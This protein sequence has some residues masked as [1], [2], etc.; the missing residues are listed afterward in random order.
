MAVPPPAHPH[1][2]TQDR[3]GPPPSAP[4]WGRWPRWAPYATAAWGV[5][6]AVV[7]TAWAA[8][9][10]TVPWT[11]RVSYAPEAQLLSAGAALLAAAVSLAGVRP[12]GGP[13]RG[14]AVT[15]AWVV[16]LPVFGWGAL[17]LPMY[18]VSLLSGSGVESATGLAQLLL[19]T[20]GSW[21]LALVGL[22]HLRRRRGRCPR[23]GAAH[24]GG[25]DGPL[26]HPPASTASR[27]TRVAVLTAMC[28]LLPWALVKTVWTLGGD[29]LGV[30]SEGWR[31]EVEREASG[32]SRALASVGL[33]VTVLAGLLAVFLMLGLVYRWGQVFP[34]WTLFLSGRRV[35]RL[36]PLVPAR[37]VGAG[38]SVYGVFLIGYAPL[39]AVGL[40]S[41]PDP[42]PP[43]T[44]ASGVLWMVEFGGLA[45]GGLGI[46]LLLGARSYAARTRPVCGSEVSGR[47]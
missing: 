4:W 14:R 16:L 25:A 21:L 41:G 33:D 39:C 2:P 1:S 8:T 34:R 5:L 43:F 19:N 29:A 46:G 28:G 15:V 36:L 13:A 12:A 20:A 11:G 32:P 37:L 23:C 24:P 10:T 47:S 7:E 31:R 3:A 30:T 6:Y 44:S 27:R 18:T 26:V 45:F 35:P 38:L 9:G 17:G 40:L 42:K 22:A